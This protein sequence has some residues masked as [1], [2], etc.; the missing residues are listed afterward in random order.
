MQ[1]GRSIRLM[2]LAS[3]QLA[4]LGGCGG[5]GSNTGSEPHT[6]PPPPP[7]PA[8]T[9]ATGTASNGAAYR[10]RVLAMGANQLAWDAGR[11]VLYGT[12]TATSPFDP[13]TLA[14]LDPHPRR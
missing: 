3:L 14:V 8:V 10:I 1:Q 12:V 7:Q 11:H 6:P 2:A 9:T 13:T 4:W 5:G